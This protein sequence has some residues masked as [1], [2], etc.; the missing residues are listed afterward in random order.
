[1]SKRKKNPDPEV[2]IERGSAEDDS[3]KLDDELTRLNS[4]LNLKHENV[5]KRRRVV[6]MKEEI[7]KLA[8]IE[9]K[10]DEREKNILADG[11]FVDKDKYDNDL[12]DRK[13]HPY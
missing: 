6:E 9:G 11:K 7:A 2:K 3:N 4:G 10:F 1:M 12:F 13:L 8:D 5:R